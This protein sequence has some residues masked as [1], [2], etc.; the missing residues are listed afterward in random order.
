MNPYPWFQLPKDMPIKYQ[1]KNRNIEHASHEV[2]DLVMEW[3]SFQIQLME[4]VTSYEELSNQLD[5]C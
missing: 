1:F 5:C 4:E 3:R 2:I